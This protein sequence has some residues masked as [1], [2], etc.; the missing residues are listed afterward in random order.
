MISFMVGLFVGGVI[1][2]LFG[3]AAMQN[4]DMDGGVDDN[5]WTRNQ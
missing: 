1:G 4:S 3:A 5:D 2:I